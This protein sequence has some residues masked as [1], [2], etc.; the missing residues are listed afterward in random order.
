[1][2]IV[3]ALYHLITGRPRIPRRHRH[4]ELIRAILDRRSVRQFTKD[5]VPQNDID[6]ILEAG[7]VAPSAVNLQTWSFITFSPQEWRST[8]GT[9]PPFD[10]P[11]L[12]LICGDIHRVEVLLNREPAP[13]ILAFTTAVIN[14]SIA[15]QNMHLMAHALGYGSVLLSETGRSGLLDMQYL[16]DRLRLP[17][18]VFPL[19]TLVVGVARSGPLVMPPK[20]PVEAVAFRNGYPSLDTHLVNQW[21]E[22]MAQAYRLTDPR[23]SIEGRIEHY[24]Q[25]FER[26]ENELERL[27]YR[28]K[29]DA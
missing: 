13:P 19:F 18:G 9:D 27:I 17:P 10:A 16:V 29:N 14:A 28:R 8:I 3:K 12:I 4:R 5:P 26:V 22:E 1:M 15:A 11:L 24:A 7:R 25:Q 2:Y 23:G 6:I 21:F 20:L